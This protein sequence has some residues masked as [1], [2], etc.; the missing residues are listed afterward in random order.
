MLDILLFLT[1]AGTIVAN[2]VI[3]TRDVCPGTHLEYLYVL[4]SLTSLVALVNA[5]IPNTCQKVPNME[6]LYCIRSAIYIQANVV[7]YAIAWFISANCKPEFYQYVFAMIVVSAS[8]HT[9]AVFVLAG[10]ILIKGGVD[11]EAVHDYLYR[12]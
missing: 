6:Y 2:I 1:S 5:M 3:A 8:V 12:A 11:C 9:I 10:T 7:L 4:T